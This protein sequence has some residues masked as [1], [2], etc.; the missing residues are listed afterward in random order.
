MVQEAMEI[1]RQKMKNGSDSDEEDDDGEEDVDSGTML[2]VDG[3]APPG[4]GDASTMKFNTDMSSGTMIQHGDD[5]IDGMGTMVI[6]DD[7]DDSSGTMQRFDTG[8][9]PNNSSGNRP[10]F[11]D[12][13]DNAGSEGRSNSGSGSKREG[14]PPEEAWKFGKNLTEMDFNYLKNLSVSELQ[15][16][17]QA[18]D[19]LMER[20]IEELRKRY[21]EKRQ[22]ILDAIDAKKRRQQNF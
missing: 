10:A 7:E 13:F 14:L 3:G 9:T 1:K 5:T 8:P 12:Y 21:N 4:G 6:N 20:E 22:P 11:M 17:L 16:R 18:L 15:A 2:K 19:P